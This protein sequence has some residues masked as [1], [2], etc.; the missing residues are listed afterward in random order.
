MTLAKRL[1]GLT[2]IPAESKI[3]AIRWPFIRAESAEWCLLATRRM[4]KIRKARI[5]EDLTEQELLSAGL[6][7]S[8]R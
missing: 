4:A 3:G 2:A 6:H 7:E 8:Q 1:A 5:S